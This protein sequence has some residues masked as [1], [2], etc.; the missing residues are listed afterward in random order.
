MSKPSTPPGV[1]LAKLLDGLKDFKG[2]EELAAM[3]AKAEK[4]LEA[5]KLAKRNARTP[6]TAVH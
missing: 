4:A 2:S 5:D 6:E 3:Q 1:N